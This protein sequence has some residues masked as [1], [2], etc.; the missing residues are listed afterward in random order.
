M[1]NLNGSGIPVI[2]PP[3]A[4]DV[5]LAGARRDL[6]HI[7]SALL[8]NGFGVAS[9][10]AVITP[11]VPVPDK[12]LPHFQLFTFYNLTSGALTLTDVRVISPSGAGSSVVRLPQV[13]TVINPGGKVNLQLAQKGVSIFGWFNVSAFQDTEVALTFKDAAGNV[14]TVNAEYTYWQHRPA[15]GKGGLATC[16]SA[17]C[18]GRGR[19]RRISQNRVPARG[20]RPST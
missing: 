20:R 12:Q 14:T 7:V 11:P 8:G 9:T 16:T 5:M 18:R 17:N 2:P 1:P 10:A 6:E 19:R 13:G 15:T 3:P 4:L